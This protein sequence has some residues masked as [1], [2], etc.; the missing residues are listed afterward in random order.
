M[1]TTL[2]KQPVDDTPDPRLWLGVVVPTIGIILAGLL[3]A[4]SWLPRLPQEIAQQWD[5]ASGAVNT[6]GSPLAISL[7]MSGS[8]LAMVLVLCIMQWSGKLTGWGR[9]GN[10]CALSAV[11]F[12]IALSVPLVLHRQLG[13]VDPLAAPDPRNAVLVLAV[14]GVAYGLLCMLVA[15]GRPLAI[16]D[17][18][19]AEVAPM[20]LGAGEIAVWSE[21][22]TGWVFLLAGGVG[23]TGLLVASVSTDMWALAP[24]G[25]VLLVLGI[26]CGRWN[27]T[28]DH[29]G[30]RCT[31]LLGLG[32]FTMPAT[33]STIADVSA[34][35]GLGEF[36]GWGLRIGS[37]SSVA[38]VFRN[39]E[40]LRVK[41]AEGR[42]LT[43]TVRDPA[44][45]AALFNAQAALASATV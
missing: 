36:L 29:R 38:L 18:A 4:I 23:G 8:A 1:T 5:W 37:N 14:A 20:N 10:V 30:L 6:Q 35:R 7:Q 41:D 26:V 34:V 43:V 15:G 25:G 44:T 31:T 2:N 12:I 32:R 24:V 45:A 19:G 3:L 40:A 27:V 21:H 28:V 17:S 9:R 11:A 22:I 33:A 42:S 13:L 16:S 39:G